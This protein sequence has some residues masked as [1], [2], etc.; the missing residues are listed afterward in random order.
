MSPLLADVAADWP[1]PAPGAAAALKLLRSAFRQHNAPVSRWLEACIG[2]FS[3]RRAHEES[4]LL[5]F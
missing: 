1:A 4:V 2:I 3:R 5:I